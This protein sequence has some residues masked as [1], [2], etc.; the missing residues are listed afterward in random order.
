MRLLISEK[1]D[2]V[3]FSI[4]QRA[5]VSYTS[6]GELWFYGGLMR[7]KD[8]IVLSHIST[9]KSYGELWVE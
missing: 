5:M 3:Y 7:D 2:F 9:V 4:E 8:S 1:R 6:Y